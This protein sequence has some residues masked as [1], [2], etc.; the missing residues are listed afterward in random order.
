MIPPKVTGL[1][2]LPSTAAVS[3]ADLPLIVQVEH[4][5]ARAARQ[6]DR[7]QQE[8]HDPPDRRDRRLADPLNALTG[9]PC[10]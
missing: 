3:A 5:G 4:L 8:G 9:I 2:T 1:T 6:G 10:S 7:G